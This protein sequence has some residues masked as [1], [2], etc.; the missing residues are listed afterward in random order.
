MVLLLLSSCNALSVVVRGSNW[1][2]LY[3]FIT[4]MEF[5][6]IQLETFLPAPSRILAIF[7]FFVLLQNPRKFINFFLLNFPT[8][9][10]I[11]KP[12]LLFY[13]KCFHAPESSLSTPAL[14]G[15]SFASQIS[16]GF[17]IQGSRRICISDL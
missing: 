1:N 16:Q 2:L 13:S 5:F 6:L 17:A 12:S 15:N 7:P 14:F 3:R 10:R 4:D 9:F 11:P 8:I